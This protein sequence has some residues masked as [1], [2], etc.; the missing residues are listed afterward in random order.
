MFRKLTGI[1]SFLMTILMLSA[2][3]LSP[4][5]S[6][7]AVNSFSV[8]DI[9]VFGSYPQTEVTD[10]ALLN[11]LNSLDLYWVSYGYY[12]GDGNGNEVPQDF[13]KYADVEY[14]GNRYRAVRFTKYRPWTIL[15]EPFDYSEEMQLMSNQRDYGYFANNVYWFKYEPLK[16]RV[17]DPDDGF[18]LC[19][20]I[21]DAQAISNT[22]Y[23]NEDSVDHDGDTFATSCFSDKDCTIYF[24]NYSKSSIRN[25]LNDNF[26]YTAFN[27]M[28]RDNIKISEIDNTAGSKYSFDTY[29]YFSSETTYDKVFL[30]SYFEVI[31]PDYG[32]NS[33]P[34]ADDKARQA[35]VTDYAKVQGAWAE[36]DETNKNYGYGLW[37]LRTAGSESRYTDYVFQ[38]GDTWFF[39]LADSVECG[40]RPAIK[41]G[42]LNLNIK[43]NVHGEEFVQI[44]SQ[45]EKIVPPQTPKMQGYVSTWNAEIP[46]VMPSESLEFTAYWTARTDT[47]YTVKIFT[48]ETDGSYIE[49]DE[50]CEGMTG[51]Y[52]RA[53][54]TLPENFVLN[55]AKSILTGM[56]KAD[57]SLVLKVY[58]DRQ[59]H[60]FTTV[61]DSKSQT[62]RYYYG[63]DIPEPAIPEKDGYKFLRWSSEIPDKMPAEDLTVTA[64]FV[65]LYS[66][67][68]I[69]VTPPENRYI[70]YGETVT[71][72]ANV[73]NMP[74]NAKI[75]W[76]IV[77]GKGVSIE[78]S[79]SGRMCYVT[80]KTNGDCIIEAYVVNEYGNVLYDEN[81]EKVCDREGIS[82]EVNLWM[83]FV[84][85]FKNLFRIV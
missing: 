19:E 85:I 76:R 32:F 52:V 73:T 49:I 65:K 7:Q 82:S 4:S 58:L 27:E 50:I 74:D 26:F 46:D 66:G 84:W 16:W 29:K 3:V 42:N 25:W 83:I 60:S 22:L 14:N 64:I 68:R 81:G 40:T 35:I 11:E 55:S 43:W 8:G 21:I 62:V 38:S 61:I 2:L 80:S 63:A 17:L 24:N 13:M 79:C 30:P 77:E 71:L 44:Y 36:T 57:N 56:I 31:N 20:N 47:K 45:G 48:M 59:K 9:V 78:P 15:S 6:A 34:S 18:L 23:Q 37:Y 41:L 53:Q 69:T 67:V 70:E 1:C 28:Q 39:K 75:K 54:Y 12:A 33:D 5:S 72:Y 10:E 51:A